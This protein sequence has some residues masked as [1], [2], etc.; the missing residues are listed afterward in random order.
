L[1]AELAG[2]DAIDPL[3]SLLFRRVEQ[4]SFHR[5]TSRAL[6]AIVPVSA[7][8]RDAVGCIVAASSCRYVDDEKE[9]TA[10][11]NAAIASLCSLDCAVTSNVLRFITGKEDIVVPRSTSVPLYGDPDSYQEGS[12]SVSLA[13]QR[14]TAWRELRRRGFPPYDP[15]AYC[16]TTLPA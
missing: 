9:A 11:S 10:D 14:R 1:L 2:A 5:E 6:H 16:K 3:L 12:S 13:E 15:A 4:A 7:L 8:T